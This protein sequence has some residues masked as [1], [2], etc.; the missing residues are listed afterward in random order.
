MQNFKEG[1]MSAEGKD[2]T[3]ESVSAMNAVDLI[4]CLISKAPEDVPSA[5]RAASELL[6]S[7]GGIKHLP[8]VLPGKLEESGICS[9]FERLKFYAGL[10][11]GQR[12]FKAALGD[13]P[14]ISRPEDVFDLMVDVR[15]QRQEHFCAVLLDAKKHV[16]RK[17][18]I[19]VGTLSM[20]VVGVREFF[21]EAIIESADTVI[22][23]HNHPS[24][25]P[26]PSAADI[27]VTKQLVQAGETLGI[28]LIDHIIVAAGEFRSLQRMGLLG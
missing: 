2:R 15:E 14:V 5:M 25:D 23:V 4:A 11:L 10:E 6:K 9:E 20:S 21:R 7:S 17:S 27:Q 24:G 3:S 18:V 22:A 19:H 16:I 12:V 1:V 8:S 28:P 26:T 13:R